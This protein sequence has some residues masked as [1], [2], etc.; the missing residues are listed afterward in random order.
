M[1]FEQIGD[2]LTAE[3]NKHWREV[4]E[5]K[6]YT[7]PLLVRLRA[8]EWPDLLALHSTRWHR[9]AVEAIRARTTLFHYC[10]SALAHL[11]LIKV[12]L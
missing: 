6:R 5:Y 11:E 4:A 3:E 12:N 8:V 2:D 1:H 10:S 7:K 9:E